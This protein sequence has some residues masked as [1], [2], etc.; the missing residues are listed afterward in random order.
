MSSELQRG[1]P[2][3][4]LGAL[5]AVAVLG[6]TAAVAHALAPVNQE[7][8]SYSFRP[9]EG[10]GEPA[11]AVLPLARSS[12]DALEL[13]LPC[14]RSGSTFRSLSLDVW[15]SPSPE[16]GA[17]QS[18]LRFRDI[19]PGMVTVVGAGVVVV[20]LGAEELLRARIKQEPGCRATVEYSDGE[21]R[22]TVP[23]DEQHAAAPGPRVA[24]ARFE[25][26]AASSE[27]SVIRVTTRE[28]G[29][30]PTPIQWVL[31]ATAIGAIAVVGREIVC[32]TVGERRDRRE[33]GR[34]RP[35]VSR[36]RPLD[37]AVF[38]TLLFWILF[39]PPFFDDGWMVASS[40]AFDDHG[41]F[42]TIYV[43]D[44]A[45]FPFGYWFQWLQ[46]LWFGLGT[47][48][49]LMRIP[50]LLLGMGTWLGVRSVARSA[51]VPR[52]GPSMWI[53]GGVFVVGFGAWGSLRAEPLIA[54]LLVASLALA[55]RFRDG[56]RGGVLVAWIAVIALAVTA[57]P[58]GVIVCSPV[59]A[60]W[61]RLWDWGRSG[62]G[63]R[64]GWWWRPC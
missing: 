54:A 40:G 7:S 59:I 61:R 1:R 11:V 23:G 64:H 28:L 45:V 22:L 51:G 30:S 6:L 62:T 33:G 4:G 47:A 63:R 53:L 25:G 5:L 8:Y 52:S 20:S 49:F 31:L 42:S 19:G 32:R 9:A 3:L 41:A 12:P 55:I 60:S 2:W 37:L 18:P 39:T 43:A 36:V 35:A 13:H 10:A 17:L 38:G 14:D 21:W 34:I 24:E 27:V 46:H 26:P 50:V 44:A 29:S 56:R 48:P 58:A 16:T 15:A 57:H